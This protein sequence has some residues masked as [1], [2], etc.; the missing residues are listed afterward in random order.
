MLLPSSSL[1]VAVAQFDHTTAHV[2]SSVPT[3]QLAALLCV[4][5][6]TVAWNFVVAACELVDATHLDMPTLIEVRLHRQGIGVIYLGKTP[7]IQNHFH[8]S[9]MLY[10]QLL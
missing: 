7:Y 3:W 4:G 6:H 9:S 10:I 8:D 1:V 2:I 5:C